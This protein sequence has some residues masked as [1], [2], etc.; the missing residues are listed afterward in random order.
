M[1]TLNLAHIY[2]PLNL[3]GER[4]ADTKHTL[5]LIEIIYIYIYSYLHTSIYPNQTTTRK[6]IFP[7]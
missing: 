7:C 4:L 6:A 3:L 1:P 5:V 2:I